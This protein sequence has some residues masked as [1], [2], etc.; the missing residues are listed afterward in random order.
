MVIKLSK[1]SNG[2]LVNYHQID[3]SGLKG[4]QYDIA[5]SMDLHYQAIHLTLTEN[6][7]MYELHSVNSREWFEEHGQDPGER[8]EYFAFCTDL[9]DDLFTNIIIDEPIY[10]D[11][12]EIVDYNNKH[13]EEVYKKWIELVDLNEKQ[14]KTI[15]KSGSSELDKNGSRKGKSKRRPNSAWYWNKRQPAGRTSNTAPANA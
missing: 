9:S 15:N 6:K 2:Y 3:R 5:K 13:N 7:Q 10:K 4:K 11:L 1:D 12:K 14:N 8:V